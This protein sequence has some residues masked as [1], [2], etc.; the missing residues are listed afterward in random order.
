MKILSL[1]R[2]LMGEWWKH[3]NIPIAWQPPLSHR[4]YNLECDDFTVEELVV[5]YRSTGRPTEQPNQW[6]RVPA[7][8]EDDVTEKVLVIS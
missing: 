6:V 8:A 2:F 1:I 4:V 7:Y 3:G 5:D